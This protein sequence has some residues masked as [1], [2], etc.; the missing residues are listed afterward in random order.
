M[1]AQDVVEVVRLLERSGVQVW[2]DGGWGVDALL[3]EQTREHKDLDLVVALS[4]VPRM[5]ALVGERGFEL[6]EGGPPKSFVLA[7]GEGRHVDV[8]PV[9]WDEQGNGVY[10]MENGQDCTYPAP[11]F[12]GSGSVLGQRMRCLTAETQMSLCHTGYELTEKDFREMD[13]LHER[14]GVEY[15]EGYRGTPTGRD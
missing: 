7:D 14:Y 5:Q 2:L 13:A 10:R 9:T 12:A 15:P 1:K 8:H 11:G 4:D 3:E 6:I